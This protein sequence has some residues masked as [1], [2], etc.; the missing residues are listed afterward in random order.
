MI[1][2]HFIL[3]NNCS[4][5]FIDSC[6]KSVLNKLYTT[7]GICKNVTER[8]FFVKMTSLGSTSSQSRKKLQKFFN[9]KLTPCNL[10][11]VSTLPLKVKRFSPS[12]IGYLRC[13][14]QDLFTSISLM[15]AM[16]PIT[17]RQNAISKSE[18]VNI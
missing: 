18:L 14:F 8:N 15:A 13:Y 4:P 17:V 6:I 12:R 5:S 11:L 3:K 2:R 16:L 10:K 9:D 1:S 7:K